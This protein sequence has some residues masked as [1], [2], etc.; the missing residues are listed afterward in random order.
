MGTLIEHARAVRD[1]LSQEELSEL[2]RKEHAEHVRQVALF[3]NA[4]DRGLCS[5]CG[6]P[7]DRKRSEHPCSHWLLRRCK[8]K[9]HELPDIARRYDYHKVASFLRWCA[10]RESLL[11]NINDLKEERPARKVFCYTV[12]WK[13]IEWTFDCSESD[14]R[15]H[16]AGH[17]SS[18]HYHFQ[19][20]IDGRQ[21]INFGDFHLPLSDRD[22]F[23]LALRNESRLHHSFGAAGSGMQDAVSADPTFIIDSV[24]PADEEEAVYHLSTTI[25]AGAEP[26]SGDE[27]ADV[28]EEA[29]ATGKSIAHVAK[30]RLSGRATIGTVVS[31]ADSVP[32]IAQR[33]EHKRR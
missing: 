18:P 1:S 5:L 9:K 26:L 25:R 32:D 6:E 17:S 10:N 30:Q 21:F 33:T 14:L 28:I 8:F 27:I 3:R 7:F 22:R 19:M 20:R 24:Q 29:R 23:N 13:N 4:Y 12:K 2:N 11:R 15:G 16:G 31:P